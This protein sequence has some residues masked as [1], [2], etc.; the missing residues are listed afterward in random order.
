M[1]QENKTIFIKR[2]KAFGWATATML[3]VALLDFGSANLELFNMPNEVTVIL[4]LVFAQI[5]KFLNSPK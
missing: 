2:L 5:T 4:G 1:T 3:A